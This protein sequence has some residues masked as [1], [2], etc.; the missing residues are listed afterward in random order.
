MHTNS[1]CFVSDIATDR[2]GLDSLR[3]IAKVFE[4]LSSRLL[5]SSYILAL[6]SYTHFL[7]WRYK[8][9]VSASIDPSLRMWLAGQVANAKSKAALT[10]STTRAAKRRDGWK[11]VVANSFADAEAETRAY[12]LAATPAERLNALE[13]LR[14][15]FYGK[16]QIGCRLQRF[17]EVV[18]AK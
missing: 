12:W 14:E 9:E 4:L 7:S 8:F 18:S 17:L 10:A 16:D 3:Q 5:H 6:T 2:E 1:T 15:P 13:K 11:I